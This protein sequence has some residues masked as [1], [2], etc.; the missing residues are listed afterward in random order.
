MDENYCVVFDALYNR[1]RFL[2]STTHRL[3]FY[4]VQGRLRF[5]DLGCGNSYPAVRGLN[6]AQCTDLRVNSRH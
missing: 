2:I 3:T 6:T 5:L 4:A 1:C